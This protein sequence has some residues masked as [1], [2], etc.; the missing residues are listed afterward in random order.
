VSQQAL[1]VRDGDTWHSLVER[2]HELEVRLLP[3]AVLAL[4]EGRVLET[5]D[6]IDS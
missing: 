4:I 6:S 3:T 2:I 1:E 5:R